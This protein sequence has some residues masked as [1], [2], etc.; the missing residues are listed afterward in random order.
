MSCTF[1]DRQNKNNAW[2]GLRIDNQ[3]LI[4]EIIYESRQKKPFFCEF[5][6]DNDYTLLVGIEL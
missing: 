6:S 3:N 5:V 2:N 4:Y 1:Y